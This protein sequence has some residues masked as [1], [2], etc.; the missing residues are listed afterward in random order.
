[1]RPVPAICIDLIH[2]FERGPHGSFAAQPYLDPIGISTVGW[3]HVCRDGDHF[4]VPLDAHGADQVA[5]FDLTTVAVGICTFLGDTAAHLT[6]GQYA[7]LIDF[8]F[9]LGIGAFETSTLAHLIKAGAISNAA[10]E[11]PKW[12]HAGGQVLPGLV[13]RREWERTLWL[14][15]KLPD[16]SLS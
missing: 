12:V 7:A 16:P 9:N 1:M 11:F 8:A 10:D 15:G 14:T 3:G 13:R 5:M 4:S 6:L 2:E